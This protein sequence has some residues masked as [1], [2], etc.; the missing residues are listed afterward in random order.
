[1]NKKK[2]GSIAA[3][4][5][6]A[7]TA[8]PTFS[9][10]ASADFS[11]SLTS[12][13]QV[14]TY[15]TN[16]GDITGY[17]YYDNKPHATAALQPAFEVTKEDGS[18]T[19]ITPATTSVSPNYVVTINGKYNV[20]ADGQ[21]IAA[22]DG[23]YTYTGGAG[24]TTTPGTNMPP[25]NPPSG[26]TT[27]GTISS[28]NTYTVAYC[29]Y[30]S[31]TK[32]YYLSQADAI[33]HSGNASSVRLVTSTSSPSYSTTYSWYSSYTGRYYASY[34]DA[35]A[36]SLNNPSYVSAGTYYGTDDYSYT[37][38][39]TYRYYSSVTNRYYKTW[40]DAYVASGNNASKVTEW[41]SASSSATYSSTY[42]WY[43]SYTGRYYQT[44]AAALAVSPSASYV[45]QGSASSSSTTYSSTYPWYSSYTKRYYQ[46]Y[47]AALAASNNIS[48]YVSQGNYYYDPYYY[49][50]Y[51]LS[52]LGGY[53]YTN[54]TT[55]TK[56]NSAVTIGKSKGWTSVIRTINS[57]KS[58][59]AYTVSMNT[60]V[61]IPSNVLTALKG[62]NVTV[63]FKFSNGAVFTL[64]GNDISSTT[65]ISPTIRYGSTSIP[66]SLKKKAVKSNSGVSSSQFTINGG[67]FGVSA[68]VTVKFNTKRA[69]CSAKLYRYNASANTLSLVS[70]SAVQNNGQCK[71]DD[72]KQGG[73]YIVVL[74]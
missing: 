47:A 64:N 65:A 33:A 72:V 2:L 4:S 38:S 56:D 45:S 11:Y 6:A 51:G 58:G 67:S 69:G 15:D 37:G 21:I 30:S 74:S 19:S 63:N 14:P 73:E 35:L 24:S 55:T 26:T 57:A 50:Y 36:A 46:T 20:A 41:T 49:Y 60:E 59:A 31:A 62:K 39:L 52:G 18:K 22:D 25:E 7:L 16:T 28:S 23:Q 44:Y 32:L 3:L 17:K 13:W 53:G 42:P 43:S 71:F 54:T 29:W 1:M 9:I 66:S 10:V 61:E 12:V 5:L 48:S 68:S 70:R 27:P 34:S 8:V 40:N